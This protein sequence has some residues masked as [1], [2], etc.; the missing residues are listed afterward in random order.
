MGKV[1]E[2]KK[3]KLRTNFDK[4]LFEELKK[5]RDEI[6]NKKNVP[7]FIILN[8]NVLRELAYYYP[9]DKG[10]FLLIKGIGENKFSDYCVDMIPTIEKFAKNVEAVSDR[11]VELNA[12]SIPDKPKVNVKERTEMRKTKVKEMIGQK[13]TIAEMALELGVTDGTIVNYIDRLFSDSVNLDVQYIKDS[14]EGY[15]DIVKSFEKHGTEK[16]GPI[17]ADLAG[18][19]EYFDITLVRVL[20]KGSK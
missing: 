15:S 6:A 3:K 5:I 18:M 17:Y 14:I 13:K 2:K 19:A 7:G 16:I 1:V 8:D 9:T 20:I 11:H 12:S 4:D 10:L